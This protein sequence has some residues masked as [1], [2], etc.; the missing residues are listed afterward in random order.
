ML[1]FPPPLPRPPARN[2][3]CYDTLHMRVT[4]FDIPPGYRINESALSRELGVSRTPLREAL[5]RLVGEGL[6][7]FETGEGFFNRTLPV[8]ELAH[9]LRLRRQIECASLRHAADHADLAGLQSLVATAEDVVGWQADEAFHL[10]LCGLGGNPEAVT[11]LRGLI[12]K[13][14]A[15]MA[16]PVMAERQPVIGHAAILMP[17]LR[18]E[19]PRAAAA[20]H[21]HLAAQDDIL[22]TATHQILAR[23]HEHAL[24]GHHSNPVS[25]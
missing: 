24:H 20:M 2:C 15:V 6:V 3:D 18:R 12:A 8:P 21:D 10:S 14:R 22:R 19:G 25:P 17:L 4:L 16:T 5:W 1:D 13:L 7:R 11:V 9:M 23:S